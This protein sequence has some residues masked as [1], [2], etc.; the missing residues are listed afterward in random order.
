MS[1]YLKEKKDLAIGKEIGA[2]FYSSPQKE[3]DL[4]YGDLP[5]LFKVL[6][7][8]KVLS[9]QA[10]PDKRLAKKLHMS[11]PSTYPDSNHKPEMLIAISETCMAMCGFRQAAEIARHLEI[12]HELAQ[13][14]EYENSKNF[15][16]LLNT[17]ECNEAALQ[18]ALSC[19]F[20]ALMKQSEAFVCEQFD[21]FKNRL[22]K[23]DHNLSALE[24]LFLQIGEQF[25]NDIG[26]F[27]IFL[28]NCINLKKGEAIFLLANVPHAYV[29]GEAV[30]CMAC[31][32]NVIRAGL[33]HK[34]R[35]VDTFCS[36]L[37]YSMRSEDETKLHPT[38]TNL[39]LDKEYLIEYRPSVDEFSVQQIRIEKKHLKSN[40]RFII[41]KCASAS[42]LLV[43]ELNSANADHH[44]EH[45]NGK[46]KLL[47]RSGHS[48][49]ADANTDVYFVCDSNNVSD[50]DGDIIL[51]AYRAYC[52][53]K[54]I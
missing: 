43:I 7:I 13:L 14:C 46:R 2:H 5:F 9:L 15:V 41:P 11:D 3:N 10:H 37:D 8:Q 44:F 25:P 39:S 48:Y 40:S 32:H 54:V 47:A 49:F 28:L 53:L 17:N 34:F 24:L 29:S 51:L 33:T 20:G 31:S 45:D 38:R 36:M 52:D 21:K 27:C 1:D 6:S 50:D 23:A 4:D 42:I 30:E 22:L 12:Y 18:A 26:C 16:N 19:C 35:D